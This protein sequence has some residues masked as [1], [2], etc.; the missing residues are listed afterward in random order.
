[1]Q[2]SSQYINVCSIAV[3]INHMLGATPCTFAA[4]TAENSYVM[5]TW[6]ER[7]STSGGCLLTW[8][9]CSRLYS[10]S[11]TYNITCTCI[12]S[13]TMHQFIT[14][15]CIRVRA[16][17]TTFSYWCAMCATSARCWQWRPS[18][19][20]DKP[21]MILNSSTYNLCL[22]SVNLNPLCILRHAPAMMHA[23]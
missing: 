17:L 7:A 23:Y 6:H 15:I 12:T 11:C 3:V 20:V 9:P 4:H 14:V 13:N 21:F 10:W 22:T 16:C 5:I 8:R 18:M 2:H 1:M 19:L